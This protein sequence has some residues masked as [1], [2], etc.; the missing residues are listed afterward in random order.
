VSQYSGRRFIKGPLFLQQFLPWIHFFLLETRTLCTA[1]FVSKVASRNFNPRY[2]TCTSN[3]TADVYRWQ[4]PFCRIAVDDLS[5]DLYVKAVSKSSNEWRIL[6]YLSSPALRSNPANHTIPIIS[7][8]HH[9]DEETVF[10]VQAKWGTDWLYP[11]L[12]N[13]KERYIVAHQLLEGLAF[14]HGH[15]I[16]HGVVPFI[17]L[18]FVGQTL[19]FR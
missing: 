12:E 17:F 2:V 6:E 15:G 1:R 3:T 14:M 8:L 11:I 4:N 9:H 19:N 16:G 7:V 18:F 10:L 5:R 13:M